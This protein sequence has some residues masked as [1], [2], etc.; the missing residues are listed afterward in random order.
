MEKSKNTNSKAFIIIIITNGIIGLGD[1]FVAIFFIFYKK[2]FDILYL[3]FRSNNFIFN[4]L[5]LINIGI[6]NLSNYSYYLAILYFLSHG[7]I[8]IFLTWALLKKRLWA[9]PIAIIFFGVFNIYQLISLPVHGSLFDI[10]LLVINAI[11]LIF[12]WAEYLLLK[13]K[14][15][16]IIKQ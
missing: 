4:K 15:F 7:I 2:I 8:K 5:S 3:F 12:V 16:S 11:V 9:Y 13:K 14:I 10:V 6:E 1:I